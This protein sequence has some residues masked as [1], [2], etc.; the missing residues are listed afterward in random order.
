MC[1]I[2]KII[3]CIIGKI[4]KW[5]NLKRDAQSCSCCK[6]DRRDRLI[7]QNVIKL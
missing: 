3:I 1:I 5:R 2:G 7:S 4:I 6:R